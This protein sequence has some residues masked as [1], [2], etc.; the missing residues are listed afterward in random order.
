MQAVFGP[1]REL[2]RRHELHAAALRAQD[3]SEIVGLRLD[4]DHRTIVVGS[5][6]HD[7]V[8]LA[9]V[10]HDV[11]DFEHLLGEAKLSAPVREPHHD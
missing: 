8:A 9:V 5:D 6:V 4:R 1:G 3:V 10:P 7:A 11:A 2:V